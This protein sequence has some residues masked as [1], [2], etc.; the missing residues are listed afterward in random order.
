MSTKTMLG[1]LFVTLI[2]GGI[3]GFAY[4]AINNSG[5]AAMLT[6]LALVFGIPSL[7]AANHELDD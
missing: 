5:D 6:G 7:I 1:I 2:L 4:A 3:G